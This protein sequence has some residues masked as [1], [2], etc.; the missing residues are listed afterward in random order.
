[1][2]SQSLLLV[3][4]NVEWQK[5]TCYFIN[6][7]N[8]S[9][10]LTAMLRGKNSEVTKPTFSFPQLHIHEIISYLHGMGIQITETELTKPTASTVQH[11][12][13]GILDTF[14]GHISWRESCSMP[15]GFS[16][17]NPEL[18]HDSINL[19]YFN[20]MVSGLVSKAGVDDFSLRDIIRPDAARLPV[21]LSAIINFDKFRQEQLILFDRMNKRA[22]DALLTKTKLIAKYE[23]LCSKIALISNK[24]AS[25]MPEVEKLKSE[26]GIMINTLREIKRE[27]SNVSSVLDQLKEKKTTMSERLTQSQF[28]I[29]NTKNECNK[30]KA[31]IVHSPEMLVQIIAE[32]NASI[33]SEKATISQFEGKSRE[34]QRK[35]DALCHLEVDLSRILGSLSAFKEDCKKLAE[36]KDS[37][38]KEKDNI[39]QQQNLARN[40]AAKESQLTRQLS[41]I[42]SKV[43]RLH[44]AQR[45]KREKTENK[46]QNL[47]LEYQQTSEDRQRA[48]ARIEGNEK[49]IKEY[50]H[51]MSELRQLHESELALV[52]SECINMKSKV[53]QYLNELKKQL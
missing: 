2:V 49:L 39:C 36:F 46:L 26:I 21:I 30:L 50:E 19:I 7:H 29:A 12:Y 34:L 22:G 18:L 28:L 6:S 14:L 17:E 4:G 53:I 20:R 32:M 9:D 52:R 41:L 40:L 13:E 51:K 33:Q 10:W 24:H 38:N 3:E 25:E 11:I 1:M 8:R 27:Q 16:C 45:E 15:D 47:Q 23:D 35:L 43:D 44:V 48:T 42:Q 31:R 37:I 5:L